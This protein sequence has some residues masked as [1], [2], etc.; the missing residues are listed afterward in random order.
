MHPNIN[1][2]TFIV[3]W[4]YIQHVDI[5]IDAADICCL[6]TLI[7]TFETGF[8]GIEIFLTP[9]IQSNNLRRLIHCCSLMK[10]FSPK[11]IM[12]ITTIDPRV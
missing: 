2:V 12:R 3:D 11:P 8:I 5:W 6:P 10:P 7:W 1:S 9:L 4:S